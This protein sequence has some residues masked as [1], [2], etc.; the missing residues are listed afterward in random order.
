MKHY[1]YTCLFLFLG[2]QQLAAQNNSYFRINFKNG[3]STDKRS[4]SVRFVKNGSNEQ[5]S[6]K[7]DE[8]SDYQEDYDINEIKSITRDKDDQLSVLFGNNLN[9]AIHNSIA[10]GCNIEEIITMLNSNANVE[11][12]YSDPNNNIIVLEKDDSVSTVFPTIDYEDP[13]DNENA[14]MSRALTNRTRSWAS[15]GENGVVAVFNYFSG[16]NNRSGQNGMVEDLLSL[17]NKH[18]YGVEYY[19]C[20]DFTKKKLEKVLKDSRDKDAYKAILIFSHGFIYNADKKENGYD[21]DPWIVLGEPYTNENGLKKAENERCRWY[22]FESK[23]NAAYSVNDIN[24][25]KN[26]LLYIGACDALRYYTTGKKKNP[27][28]GWDGI[29]VMSQAHALM[30]FHR[31]LNNKLNLEVALKSTWGYDKVVADEE[32]AP[33]FVISDNTEGVAFSRNSEYTYY[34]PSNYNVTEVFFEEPGYD[35]VFFRRGEPIDMHESYELHLKGTVNFKDKHPGKIRFKIV[36]V[37]RYGTGIE[38]KIKIK[39]DGTFDI[40]WKLSNGMDGLYDIIVGEKENFTIK[41]LVNLKGCRTFVYSSKFKEN[42]ATT[43]EVFSPEPLKILDEN[44]DQV[45]SLDL[46]NGDTINLIV[47][48]DDE[49]VY[50]FSSS[51]QSVAE[52]AIDGNKVTIKALNPGKTCITISDEEGY[53][54]STINVTVEEESDIKTIDINGV[55]FD[56][57]KVEGGDFILGFD[58]EEHMSDDVK[59][60]NKSH[61]VTLSS[62]YLGKYEV[63]QKQWKAI[64]GDNPSIIVGDNLPVNNVNWYDCE[65]FVEELNKV[66]PVRFRM[67]T[68]AE[69]YYAAWGGIYNERS[70]YYS[71]ANISEIAWHSTNSGDEIHEGGLKKPNTLGIYDM[72]GNV[73][74]WC[75]DWYGPYPTEAVVNPKGPDN[76]QYRL[77]LGGSFRHWDFQCMLRDLDAPDSRVIYHGFRL[78]IDK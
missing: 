24:V 49:E 73:S 38:D 69:W 18:N 13:F 62:Y 7:Q 17:L 61:K 3:E 10:L 1:I 6:L 22:N 32:K 19:E 5:Y 70:N 77:I 25:H 35:K 45:D 72:F 74:E 46:K 63:T 15:T 50:Y 4:T 33:A 34:Y 14:I 39:K 60:R 47:D 65:K 21:K 36:P 66:S 28:I 16:M 30:L 78:A 26:C 8:S 52:A 76:G 67:P 68:E 57:V 48:N 40:N 53:F 71:G 29:N 58:D 20:E 31:M 12:A 75:Y 64:M 2:I 43:L 54:L 9:N 56:F 59:E 37:G 23:Y 41:E 11:D 27:I 55:I 44:G 42:A 51:N